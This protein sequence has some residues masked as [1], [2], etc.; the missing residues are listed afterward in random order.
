M[1]RIATA[2]TL[3]VLAAPAAHADDTADIKKALNDQLD[4]LRKGDTEGFKKTLTEKVRNGTQISD[5]DV[6]RLGKSLGRATADTLVK[7]ITVKDTKDG[8]RAQLTTF[9]KSKVFGD[10][11]KVDGKWLA[12]S[13]WF[14]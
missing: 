5:A 2:I 14:E 12:D 3:L 11:L 8:P 13:T 9:R 1:L 4:L 10:F 6:K 7:S